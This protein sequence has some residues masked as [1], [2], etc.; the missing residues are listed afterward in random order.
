MEPALSRQARPA[1]GCRNTGI[2]LLRLIAAV[3]VLILHILLRGGIL[4][5]CAP[6]SYQQ[7]ISKA[8]FLWCCCAV[9]LFG[10]ISGF[11]GYTDEEHPFRL[12]GYARLWLEVV[13]YNL[14]FTLLALWRT[15]DAAGASDLLRAF[16]PVMSDAHWYFTGYTYLFFLIPVLNAGIRHCDDRLLR[17]LFCLIVLVLVPVESM[18]GTMASFGGFT[19]VW[20]IFLYV[21][22]A[23][24]KKTQVLSGLPT[25]AL[26]AAIPVLALV[27]YGL[28]THYFCL[29]LPG[30]SFDSTVTEK[31]V[32]PCHVLSA[33]TYVLLFARFRFGGQLRTLL[34]WAAP[35]AFAVYLINTQQ[36][37]WD[38]Y[39]FNHF[40]AW[41]GN[42]P[43]GIVVRVVLTA[44]GFTLASL[45]IDWLRRQLFRLFGRHRYPAQGREHK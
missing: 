12:S 20:L 31:Y 22:G 43:L 11:V 18:S 13:F 33:I 15:P 21:I 9:N 10:I 40:A 39:M 44:L 4:G 30:F 45:V 24:L 23:I 34:A 42:S 2:D 25:A 16:F 28:N 37:V 7:Q 17:R 36:F 6:G 29:E 14:L 41:A 26:L 5:A 27:S 19:A 3:Y 38:G 8:L 1:A 32:F 35:G